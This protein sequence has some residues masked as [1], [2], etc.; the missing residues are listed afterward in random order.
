MVKTGG[1]KFWELIIKIL[2]IIVMIIVG[3]F[4]FAIAMIVVYAV[5]Y[6]IGYLVSSIFTGTGTFDSWF[7]GLNQHNHDN[8]NSM[9]GMITGIVAIIICAAII[10][11]GIIIS[12]LKRVWKER[13]KR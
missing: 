12:E 5:T 10:I 13:R 11:G 1:Q 2:M 7:T 6:S 3:I 8:I 9:I 4:V